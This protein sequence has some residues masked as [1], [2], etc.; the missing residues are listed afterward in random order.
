[1]NAAESLISWRN[2]LLFVLTKCRNVPN[3]IGRKRLATNGLLKRA[4]AMML[5]MLMIDMVIP[6]IKL[7]FQSYE[8]ATPHLVFDQRKNTMK[9]RQKNSHIAIKTGENVGLLEKGMSR[10]LQSSKKPLR[11]QPGFS[12]S[13]SI[14]HWGASMKGITKM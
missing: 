7:C 11:V 13:A 12:F 3:T 14:H 6:K 4:I 1:M 9:P 5:S 2:C 8:R 10:L